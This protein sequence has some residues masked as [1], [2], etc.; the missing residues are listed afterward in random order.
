[1]YVC[2]C[3]PYFSYIGL[4]L[5]Y[6]FIGFV[7]FYCWLFVFIYSCISLFIYP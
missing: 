7:L 2:I 6:L 1:M 5:F 3:L 4:D